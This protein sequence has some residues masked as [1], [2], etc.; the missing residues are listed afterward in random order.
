MTANALAEQA[1]RVLA[2]FLEHTPDVT[3]WPAVQAL[4]HALLL[5][6][7]FTTLIGFGLTLAL[8]WAEQ[9][10]PTLWQM[11]ARLVFP[12]SCTLFSLWFCHLAIA[13]LN[14]ALVLVGRRLW[15]PPTSLGALGLAALVWWLPWLVTVALLA[16]TYLVRLAELAL[17]ASLSGLAAAFLATPLEA[18][19]RRW[20]SLFVS[21][22]A[23][24]FLQAVALTLAGALAGL[25]GG[26]PPALLLVSVAELVLVWRLPALVPALASDR[27]G[28]FLV[29]FLRYL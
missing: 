3:T 4:W 7:A 15:L 8:G 29:A 28:A 9:M 25:L 16:I 26:S 23:V 21:T 27:V 22:L 1:L 18:L 17:L 10:A 20:L 12:V 19:G 6:A 24:Q 5:L 13:L 14:A 2:P 11:A